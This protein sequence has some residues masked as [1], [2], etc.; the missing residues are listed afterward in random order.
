MIGQMVEEANESFETLNLSIAEMVSGNNT[1]AE[2]SS[3]ISAAM[4]DVVDFCNSM[5]TSFATINNL[6]MQLENNNNSITQV[7]NQTNLLSL[8]ASIEAA[9]A[10][11]GR[12][13]FCGCGT[14]N[15]ELKRIQQ[16]YGIRQQ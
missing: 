16:R 1:N 2:E 4:S 5:K 3:N 7:A 10:G 14:G 11:N 13:R 12:K 8:N 15:Q 6:L 9:R